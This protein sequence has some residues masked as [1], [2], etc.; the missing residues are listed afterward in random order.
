MMLLP[1]TT[2][3]ME[4]TEVDVRTRSDSSS[5]GSVVGLMADVDVVVVDAEGPPPK[6]TSSWP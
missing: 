3:K 2:E 1:V 6:R 4:L 5:V